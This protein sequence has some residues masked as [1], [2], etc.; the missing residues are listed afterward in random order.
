MAI[1]FDNAAPRTSPLVSASVEHRASPAGIV[2]RRVPTAR[3]GVVVGCPAA[4]P[5]AGGLARRGIRYRRSAFARR[6]QLEASL[7]ELQARAVALR[8]LIEASFE[9]DR[10]R[11]VRPVMKRCFPLVGREI[12]AL[13]RL[14]QRARAAA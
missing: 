9:Q 3:H 8:N 6:D 14:D 12:D 11:R 2:A 4:R 10:S 13:R 7:A 1:V 5:V